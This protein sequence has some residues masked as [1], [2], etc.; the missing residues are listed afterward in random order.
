MANTTRPIWAKGLML[1]AG[2]AV[3]ALV[4]VHVVRQE[5]PS[6]DSETRI[7]VTATA[8]ADGLVAK[9]DIAGGEAR[10]KKGCSIV[11]DAERGKCL[12]IQTGRVRFARAVAGSRFGGPR[13]LARDMDEAR[14]GRALGRGGGL[15]QIGRAACDEVCLR[16]A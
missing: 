14:E 2:A 9:W 4:V 5:S 10:V 15:G 3:L 16:H 11:E 6:G 1:C 7:G 13:I 8:G 12:N